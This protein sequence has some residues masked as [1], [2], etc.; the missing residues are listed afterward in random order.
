MTSQ[1]ESLVYLKKRSLPQEVINSLIKG[2]A[3]NWWN[4]IDWQFNLESI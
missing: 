1:L 2:N 3:Y 4:K